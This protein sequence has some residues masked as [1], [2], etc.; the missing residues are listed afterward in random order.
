MKNLIQRVR[1]WLIKKLGGYTAK[2]YYTINWMPVRELTID[3]RNV[4]HLTSNIKIARYGV[5]P[6]QDSIKHELARRLLPLIEEHMKIMRNYDA[7]NTY[8]SDEV[9][10]MASIDIVREDGHGL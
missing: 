10:F 1:D 6:D 7:P 2:E 4:A 8:M 9:V 3:R 5:Y